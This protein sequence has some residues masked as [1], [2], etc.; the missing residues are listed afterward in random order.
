MQIIINAG[1]DGTRLWPL[2]TKK[3]PKQF[4]PITD[5]ESLLQKSFFRLIKNYRSDQV[6][7]T[8]NQRHQSLVVEQLGPNFNGNNVLTEPQRRD[9]FAAVIAHAAV[10]ASKTSKTE[11]LAFISSD[12]YIDNTVD[13]LN[14]IETFDLVDKEIQAQSFKIILPATKPYYP[15]TGYG[16]IK[17]DTKSDKKTNAVLAFKE[18]PNQ[19]TAEKFLASGDYFWNLG[20]FAFTYETLEK[21]IKELYPQVA[22]VLDSIYAKGLITEEDYEQIPKDSFDFAILEKAT[23]L[24]TIDMTLSSWDDLGSFEVVYGYLDNKENDESFM[25]VDGSGNKVKTTSSRPIAFA[26]VSNLM[27]VENENGLLI[28]DPKKSSSKVKEIANWFDK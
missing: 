22:I 18:K 27:V 21:I 23:G 1:G 14:Y 17:F 6:W 26:G 4:A 15:A 13:Y 8:T 11:T 28:I 16:Y 9:T 5:H 2:S 24:G 7:V 19:A 10:V 3:H 12:H 20:Y 25:Q